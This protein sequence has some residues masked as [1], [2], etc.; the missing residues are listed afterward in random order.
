M[1][2]YQSAFKYNPFLWQSYQS[3]GYVY[4]NLKMYDKASEYLNRAIEINPSNITLQY[5]LGLIYLNSGQNEKAKEMFS[6]IL[7]LDP[8]NQ[9]AANVLRQISPS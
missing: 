3:L 1:G 9:D 6:N 7:K 5:N 8:E 4:F 2:N